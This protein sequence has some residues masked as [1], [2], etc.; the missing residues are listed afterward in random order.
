MNEKFF[1][2]ANTFANKYGITKPKFKA[3]QECHQWIKIILSKTNNGLKK[4]PYCD[5]VLMRK[6]VNG[7]LRYV[8]KNCG[9][10]YNLKQNHG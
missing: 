8:C 10:K 7:K 6:L 3:V 4:C 9:R 5:T 2:I 1:A